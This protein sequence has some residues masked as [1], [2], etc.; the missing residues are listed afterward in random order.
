MM[1]RKLR[2]TQVV[3]SILD[4]DLQRLLG[5]EKRVLI[6]DLDD[7]PCR[8]RA[9]TLNSQILQYLEAIQRVGFQI[10]ILSSWRR[11]AREPDRPRPPRVVPSCSRGW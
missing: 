5:F 7:T 8:R 6:F 10:G 4:L 9:N 11:N 2:S 3:S 1:T